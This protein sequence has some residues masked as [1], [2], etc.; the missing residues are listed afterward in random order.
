[1]AA[2]RISVVLVVA[3]VLAA[4]GGGAYYFFA[5]F[6]ADERLRGAR[7]QVETWEERWQEA[8]RC[9]LGKAPLAAKLDDAIAGRALV[10]GS[11]EAAGALADCSR[12]I[13]RL[14]RPEGNNTGMDVVEEAWHAVEA[15]AVTVAK[16]YVNHLQAPDED[17]TFSAALEQ[18]VSARAALRQSVELP[19]ED[20][21]MGPAPRELPVA[22]LAV[23]GEALTEL[24][25][26][27]AG[28]EL[29]GRAAIGERWLTARVRRGEGAAAFTIEAR[30]VK[31]DVVAAVPD[32][33]WGATAAF[34]TKGEKLT[35]KLSA[36]ALDAEGGVAA[37]VVAASAPSLVVGAVVG[38]S[39]H[40]AIVY[41]DAG[42]RAAVSKDGGASWK[43]SVL[44]DSSDVNIFPSGLGYADVIWKKELA[45]AKPAAAT[46]DE[47]GDEDAGELDDEGLGAHSEV[48][49]QRIEA[50]KLP[51]LGAPVT[52]PQ[53]VLL[54]ACAAASAPWALLGQGEEI[55]LVRMDD[56]STRIRVPNE[57]L[58][59][60]VGCDDTAVLLSA[61]TGV[62][63]TCRK[64]ACTPFPWRRLDGLGAVV[65]GKAMYVAARGRLL[66]VLTAEDAP[67]LVRLPEGAQLHALVALD[68]NPYLV[69]EQKNGAMAA[70]P[71]P[72]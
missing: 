32:A 13:S 59:E 38:S 5:V 57:D 18:L 72:R 10:V 23:G 70:A 35:I 56:L 44:A 7:A 25:V 52:V 61:G 15:H 36:G 45:A 64:G 67:R 53:A 50:A 43:S 40:R 28:G 33:T 69:I 55:A 26:T 48:S 51:L 58:L 31:P 42:V 2:P 12:P 29:S 71:L 65:A 9:V 34:E 62:L 46:G 8:R 14:T 21:A 20:G 24:L 16:S 19:A 39:A 30:P 11:G 22:P 1:M 60:V 4:A 27:P 3:G 54:R 41:V 37:P 66:A 63:W 47:A 17:E 6:S 49:W 68:G